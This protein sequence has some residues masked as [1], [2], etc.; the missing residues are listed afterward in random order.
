MPWI[1]AARPKTLAAAFIPVLVATSLSNAYFNDLGKG[2]IH[3]SFSFYAL[4]S[5]IFIQIGT[6]LI[7]DALD[8]KKGADTETRIGPQRVTQNGL[9]NFHQVLSGGLICFFI[10]TFFGLPL[11]RHS[12]LPIFFLGLASLACG[13]LYTGGKY[14]LAYVGLGDLFVILFFGFGAICGVYYIQTGELSTPAF[15]ASIQIGLLATTLIAI[16]NFRDYQSDKL[17]KKYTLAARFG[18]TFSRIEI[19]FLFGVAFALNSY[20]F[21]QGRYFAAILPLASLPLAVNLTIDLFKNSPSPKFN[22]Y[23]AKAAAIEIIFGLGLS[24]GFCLHV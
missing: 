7:N 1:L 21:N 3:L 16:N 23:L 5:A 13:Y 20:W 10:A 17:V 22:T 2:Q 12:G 15:I 11:I 8:F 18:P 9:L 24:L 19:A 6:N 4:M 14:P